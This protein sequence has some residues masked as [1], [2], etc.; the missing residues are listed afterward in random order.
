MDDFGVIISCCHKDYNFAKGCCESVRYNLGNVPI[1]LIIDGSFP[2]Q[3]LTK[4]Y[5]I[6]IINW[7]NVKH[8][9]LKSKSFGFGVTKMIAFWESPWEKFLFLDADTVVWGDLLKYANFNKFDLIIDESQISSEEDISDFFFDIKAIERHFPD[10][11]WRDNPY[12]VTGVFFAKR[13]IFSLEQYISLLDF[14]AQYP[15]IF[16]LGEQ[17][18]LNFM[19]F[20]AVQAGKIKLDI[21]KMQTLVPRYSIAQLQQWFRIGESELHQDK[22]HIASVIHWAGRKPYWIYPWAFNEPM[23]FFRRR[24]LLNT[25]GL[26]GVAA[27]LV[28]LLEDFYRYR[29]K[30]RFLIRF[31]S[32]IFGKLRRRFRYWGGRSPSYAK[33]LE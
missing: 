7:D 14:N 4:K 28:L 23:Q 22:Q 9:E 30:H 19:A 2:T 15:G 17:G 1:C 31:L 3:N 6:K 27:E 5:G 24:F 26:S 11:Q 12:W 8:P 13:D 18:I 32:I 10:F 20:Q 29:P 25:W 16:K 21:K 33:N